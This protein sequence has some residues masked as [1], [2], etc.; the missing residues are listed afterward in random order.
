MTARALATTVTAIAAL[1]LLADG[2]AATKVPGKVRAH[3][4]VSG[5]F[6]VT[7][8]TAT[9]SHPRAIYLRLIGRVTSGSAVIACSRDFAISSNHYE[10]NRAGLYR[11]PVKPAHA[12]SCQ[13]VGSV[14]GS[15]RVTIEIRST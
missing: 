7:A 9:I 8:V 2:A 12:E 11:I 5:Q 4:T 1:I 14:G 15:G 13:V 6:A 3:K 10:H